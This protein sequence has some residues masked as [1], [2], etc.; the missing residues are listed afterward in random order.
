MPCLQGGSDENSAPCRERRKLSAAS[1]SQSSRAVR[2]TD[3]EAPCH[4]PSVLT[5]SRSRSPTCHNHGALAG[6]LV[7]REAAHL[8]GE[9]AWGSSTFYSGSEPETAL[10][11]KPG[12]NKIIT[13]LTP[14]RTPAPGYQLGRSPRSRTHARPQNRAS[15]GSRS[16]MDVCGRNVPEDARAGT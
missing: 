13:T 11:Y 7:M 6:R 9:G 8:G 5:V 3:R 16:R 2:G 12:V 10:K 4:L 1:L 14:A 15:R